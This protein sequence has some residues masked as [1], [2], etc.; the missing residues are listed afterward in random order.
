M[1][2]YI[3]IDKDYRL[4]SIELDFRKDNSEPYNTI[5]FAGENG[6]GKTSVLNAISRFLEGSFL[7]DDSPIEEVV[8]TDL[9]GTVRTILRKQEA[10]DYHRYFDDYYSYNQSRY[11]LSNQFPY[12]IRNYPVVFSEARTGF[13]INRQKELH[14]PENEEDTREYEKSGSDYSGIVRMLNDL[15]IKDN[16]NYIRFAK[17]NPD[18]RYMEYIRQQSNIFRFKRAFESM[19]EDLKYIGRS[20]ITEEDSIFFERNGAE[21]DVGNLSTGEKQIVFRGADL[22]SHVDEGATVIVDEPELSLHPKWQTKILDY[23]RSLL[24]DEEGNQIAQLIVA[25]HSP[26]VIQSAVSNKSDVKTIILKREGNNI[27]ADEMKDVLL[28]DSSEV[29]YLAFDV[30]K[31]EYHMQLFSAI[32]RILQSDQ[33]YQSISSVDD[34]IKNSPYYEE[35]K[36]KKEDSSHGHYYTLPVYIRN[37]IDHPES[38]RVYTNEEITTSIELLRKLLGNLREG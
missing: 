5:V 12:D 22:L 17:T 25:T 3:H 10:A 20:P 31:K 33:S 7:S 26:Y 32:H 37:A 23:Y 27:I 9:T 4:G 24:S 34:Y 19:F 15:E 18:S 30:D 35:Q 14:T 29:N 8:Y 28:G 21:F 38:G 2:G 16:D 13:E 6:C 1:I 11:E 36:H